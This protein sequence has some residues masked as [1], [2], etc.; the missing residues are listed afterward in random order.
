MRS[1]E[2]LSSVLS[3]VA[4]LLLA[5]IARGFLGI[6]KDFRRF[7]TEHAWL[8]ATTLWTRDKVLRIMESLDL[9]LDGEPPGKLPHGGPPGG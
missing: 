7:M 6:R 1:G 9:P 3:G 5:S 2:I 4:V 8:I